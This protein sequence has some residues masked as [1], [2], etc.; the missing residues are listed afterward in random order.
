MSIPFT[1]FLP[2][3]GMFCVLALGILIYFKD[4]KSK[5]NSIFGLITISLSVILFGTFEMFLSQ[6]EDEAILWDR[7]I[8]IGAVFLPALMYHFSI[9]FSKKK[10]E[11]EYMI[12]LLTLAITHTDIVKTDNVS[13]EKPKQP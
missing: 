11:L 4:R 3:I 7:F 10:E 1:T 12:K 9:V 6:T 5:L 2:L 13:E 8:Y